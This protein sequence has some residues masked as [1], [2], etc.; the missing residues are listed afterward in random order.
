MPSASA[1]R[2]QRSFRVTGDMLGAGRLFFRVGDS[3]DGVRAVIGHHQRSIPRDCDTHGASPQISVGSHKASQEIL[4]F[5]GGVAILHRH[6]DNF[7]S[8]AHGA[9]PRTV[10]GG[11][12]MP[13]MFGNCLPS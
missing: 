2:M 9:V 13:C 7:I 5:A 1:Q 3:P 10:F 12:E 11:E 6:Q 8:C 4:V